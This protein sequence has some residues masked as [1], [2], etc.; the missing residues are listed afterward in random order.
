MAGRNGTDVCSWHDAVHSKRIVAAGFAAQAASEEPR[1]ERVRSPRE[2]DMADVARVPRPRVDSAMVK[3]LARSSRYQEM[4][5]ERVCG[6]IEELARRGAGQPGYM[7]RV[8]RLTLLGPDI[9][10]AI[11]EGRQPEAMRLEGLLEGLPVE[12]EGQRREFG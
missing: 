10:E 8:L 1:R 11:L 12:W 5:D 9:V 3:A 7:S 6:T 2:A 4:R